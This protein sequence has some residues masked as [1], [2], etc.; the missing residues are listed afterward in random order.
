MFLS[1][2]TKQGLP[3]GTARFW[4]L[5]GRDTRFDGALHR[6]CRGV[7][8]T[9]VLSAFTPA[10]NLVL[11]QPSCFGVPIALKTLNT[12]AH[13]QAF[14]PCYDVSHFRAEVGSVNDVL[15]V[16]R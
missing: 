6:T 9:A 4:L 12:Q 2:V 15:L 10:L 8:S 13:Q 5:P 1:R 11:G 14:M 3:G 7:W 16:F